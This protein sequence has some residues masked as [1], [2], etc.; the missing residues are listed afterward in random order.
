MIE[1]F[2]KHYQYAKFLSTMKIIQTPRALYFPFFNEV[3]LGLM[4]LPLLIPVRRSFNRSR[5]SS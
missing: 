2:H 3:E 4:I 5:H 1:S